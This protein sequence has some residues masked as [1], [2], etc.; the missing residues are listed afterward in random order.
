MCSGRSEMEKIKNDT[1]ELK[2]Q[3]GVIEKKLDALV[4]QGSATTSTSAEDATATP[5]EAVEAPS[6]NP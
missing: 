6:R 2:Q 4:P 3:L 1:T 5:P